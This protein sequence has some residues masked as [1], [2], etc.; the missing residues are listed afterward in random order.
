MV[1]FRGAEWTSSRECLR[2]WFRWRMPSITAARGSQPARR[3][4][5]SSQA[6]APAWMKHETMF[7]SKGTLNVRFHVNWWEGI[8]PG[9]SLPGRIDGAGFCVHSSCLERGC[10]EE[11]AEKELTYTLLEI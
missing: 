3:S 9:I 1:S 5:R 11:A 8:I 10:S 7:L 2:R 6:P 4:R